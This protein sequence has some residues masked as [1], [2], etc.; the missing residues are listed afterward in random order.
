MAYHILQ[1]EADEFAASA[2]AAA[3][4]KPLPSSADLA[5]RTPPQIPMNQ[6]RGNSLTDTRSGAREL[7]GS[8]TLTQEMS[9]PEASKAPATVPLPGAVDA[10]NYPTQQATKQVSSTFSI[11]GNILC[12]LQNACSGPACWAVAPKLGTSAAIFYAHLEHPAQDAV[13]AR[14]LQDSIHCKEERSHF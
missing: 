5:N 10:L 6:S 4:G 8:H 11:V 14:A 12:I 3:A 2:A 13:P 9:A 1:A 7:P